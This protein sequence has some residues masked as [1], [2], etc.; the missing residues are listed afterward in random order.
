MAYKRL[1]EDAIEANVKTI[2]H[3]YLKSVKTRP[4]DIPV[5]DASIALIINFLVNANDIA[6]ELRQMND[7][8]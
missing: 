3:A 7:V 5:I 8:E 2:A 6:S 1:T 4:E